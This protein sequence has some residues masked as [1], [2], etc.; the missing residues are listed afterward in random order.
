M[1]QTT[2]INAPFPPMGQQVA[3]GPGTLTGAAIPQPLGA[4]GSA[5]LDV[6]FFDSI[7]PTVNP[8]IATVK[9]TNG[10]VASNSQRVFHHR[11]VCRAALHQFSRRYS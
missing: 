1:S 5:V 6:S 8:A 9:T 10:Y 11:P 3:Q 4:M 7:G 2:V